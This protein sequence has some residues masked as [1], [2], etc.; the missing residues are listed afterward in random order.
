LKT[1]NNKLLTVIA[2]EL[3]VDAK[4]L[5]LGSGPG[6]NP[7]EWDSFAHITL[8]LAIEDNFAVSFTAEEFASLDSIEKIQNRLN[9]EEVL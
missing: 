3:K 8:M 6:I 2:R 4:V 5:E 1:L 7:S 9:D